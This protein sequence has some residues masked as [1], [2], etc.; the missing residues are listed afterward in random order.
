MSLIQNGGCYEE[1]DFQYHMLFHN[2]FKDKCMEWMEISRI[3][4]E[5]VCFICRI[6]IRAIRKVCTHLFNIK[7]IGSTAVMRCKYICLLYTQ[8]AHDVVSTSIFGWIKVATKFEIFSLALSS[9]SLLPPFC[10]L[11]RVD[12]SND[13]RKCFDRR[14]VILQTVT[15][16]TSP[17]I[18]FC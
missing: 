6:K 15:N 4:A 5:R 16:S 18:I 12:H 1:W 2:I 8:R 14:G 3:I 9:P 11:A 13:R 7:M 17:Y 10:H